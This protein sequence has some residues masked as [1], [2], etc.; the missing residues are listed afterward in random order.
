MTN[1]DGTFRFASVPPGRYTLAV[2]EYSGFSAFSQENVEVNLSRGTTA[3]L[4]LPWQ[5]AQRM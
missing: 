2:A 1:A 4:V 3:N 5:A